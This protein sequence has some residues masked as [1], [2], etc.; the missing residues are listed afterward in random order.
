MLSFPASY[1]LSI[2]IGLST[3]I[4]LLPKFINNKKLAKNL[5]IAFICL[6]LIACILAVFGCFN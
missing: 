5:S 1:L 3:L 4:I 2:T 6:L